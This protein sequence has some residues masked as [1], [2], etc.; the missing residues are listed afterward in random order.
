[1]QFR[2]Q[3]GAQQRFPPQANLLIVRLLDK[4]QV[5]KQHI[6]GLM[7]LFGIAVVQHAD[8]ALAVAA[9]HLLQ[10]GLHQHRLYFQQMRQ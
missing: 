8:K 7:H 10:H 1:M 5:D 9:A 6:G 4:R 2:R 3:P